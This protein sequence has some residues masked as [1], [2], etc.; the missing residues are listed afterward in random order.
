MKVGF[1]HSVLVV[2]RFQCLFSLMLV[3]FWKLSALVITLKLPLSTRSRYINQ[4][5]V[6]STISKTTQFTY[7]SK[8]LIGCKKF[9]FER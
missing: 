7:S 5:V 4:L 9:I 6:E 1:E 8:F 3:T 2:H